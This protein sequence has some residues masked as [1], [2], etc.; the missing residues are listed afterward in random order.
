MIQAPGG[1]RPSKQA[2]LSAKNLYKK[3]L[4]TEFFNKLIHL[5]YASTLYIRRKNSTY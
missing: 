1:P 3:P 5:F 2:G 4:A